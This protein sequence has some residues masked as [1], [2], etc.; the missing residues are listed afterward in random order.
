MICKNASC[1]LRRKLLPIRLNAAHRCARKYSGT[2][3]SLST[4]PLLPH[5]LTGVTSQLDQISPRYE[6]DAADINILHTP[7]EFYKTLKVHCLPTSSSS[8]CTD[9]NA[10][11]N[12]ERP[13]TDIY[14][15]IIHRQ[16]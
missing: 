2:A 5:L 1:Q 7:T 3:P 4:R 9:R 14:I 13:S 10:A 6:L 8:L 16:S 12:P 11:K 15:Y